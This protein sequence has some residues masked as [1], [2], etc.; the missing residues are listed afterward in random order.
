MVYS[1]FVAAFHKDMDIKREEMRLRKESN[2][3]KINE[4][5]AIL[6]YREEMKDRICK[7]Y[8]NER[9]RVQEEESPNLSLENKL[10]LA[11]GV[12]KQKLDNEKHKLETETSYKTDLI[13][14]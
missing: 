8:F 10:K 13:K 14:T 2:Q 7:D 11:Q 12:L 6:K 4:L 3:K 1:E 9:H 5:E